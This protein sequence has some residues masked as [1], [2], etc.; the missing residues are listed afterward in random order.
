MTQEQ[1]AERMGV[2]AQAVSKWENNLSCPDISV[3]PELAEV[4]G[5]SVDELLGKTDSTPAKEGEVVDEDKDKG[6]SVQWN[7]GAK[8]GS[9]CFA[10]Y[11]LPLAPIG[12]LTGGFV[13]FCLFCAVPN[14][15]KPGTGRQDMLPRKRLPDTAPPAESAGAAWK[16]RRS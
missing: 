4:F 13:S 1:L 16:W 6:I 2:S 11:I 5:I 14:S 12:S 9:I 10:L 8:S 7:W 3:L 15:G